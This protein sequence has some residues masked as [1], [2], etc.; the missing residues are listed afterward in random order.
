GRAIS[1]AFAD[2]GIQV[3]VKATVRSVRQESGEVVA[4]ASVG[5]RDRQYRAEKLLVATGR[6]PNTDNI[7]IERSGV[8]VGGRGEV[9]VNEH[10]QTIVGHIFAAGDAIGAQTESQM[11]TPVGSHDG[12]IAARN[13]LSGEPMRAVNHRVI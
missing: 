8:K 6:R 7:D 10:L 1:E 12:G 4:V 3:L 11:A 9:E 5:G 13:A 2:E